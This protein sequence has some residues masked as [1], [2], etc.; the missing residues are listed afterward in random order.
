MVQTLSWTFYG[1]R[2]PAGGRIVQE[3]FDGLLEDERDEARD[4]LAYL[5]KLPRSQWVKPEYFPLGDGLSE[6][7]FTVNTLKRIYR[8]YSCFWPKGK[9]FSYTFLL[10]NNKK[11]S[12]PKHDIEEEK[13]YSNKGRRQYMNL[14][15]RKSLIARLRRSRRAR[16]Q[17]VDSHLGK[18]I[19]HQLRAT[20]E[21]L[22]WNQEK[23]AMEAGMNQNAISR[24]ESASYGKPTITTLKRLASA[25]DIGI[26]VRFVPFSQMVDWVNGTPRVDRGLTSESLAVPSFG[27]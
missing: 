23:L 10:G 16:E 2:T 14:Y 18:G 6:V 3:W 27:E 12:N 9:R 8:I 7:R 19:S 20:R 17:F 22:G 5:Q 26:I 15:S 21:R 25:M 11:L 13:N 1:Y 24:L 4:T